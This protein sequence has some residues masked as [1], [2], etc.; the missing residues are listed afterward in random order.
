MTTEITKESLKS[1]SRENM[2]AWLEW[3]DHNGTY[4]DKDSVAEFGEVITREEALECM[5][6]QL[7]IENF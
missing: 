6:R 1:W 5:L 7:E 4:N 3:N 2:I